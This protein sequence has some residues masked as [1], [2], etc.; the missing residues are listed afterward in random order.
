[1][2][3]LR[4][5]HDL[6]VRYRL[7]VSYSAVFIL[8][9]TVGSIIV[10]TL[11]RRTIEA[12]IESKLNNS[13]ATILDM[14][15]T[16]ITVSIKNHLRAVA[17]K[18][19]EIAEHF[20]SL[21]EQGVL[22]EEDPKR[23]AIAILF[24]QRIGETGYIY[25]AN[26]AGVAVVHPQ[27]AVQG[28]NFS[29][30][31]FV[32]EQMSRKEG[33]I[34]YEWKNPGDEVSRPKALYMTYFPAWDWIISASSYREEFRALINTEDFRE[35]ILSLR[36]GQTG[37]SYVMDGK[38]NLIIHPKLEGQN[39]LESS[40]A[41]GRHFIQEICRQKSGKMIYPWKNPDEPVPR[42]K[43]VIFNYVPELDWIVASSGYLDELYSPLA[44]VR[45][46]FFTTL[47]VSLLLV[48]PVTTRIS[49]SITS[50]LKELMRRFASAGTRDL[51]VRANTKSKD[52]LGQLG[53]YFNT[54][55][56]RLEEYNTSL[57]AEIFERKQAEQALRVSEEMFSKAFRLSP[58]GI[59]IASLKNRVVVDVN[60]SLLRATGYSHDEVI[61]KTA[62]ELGVF[63]NREEG[64][65]LMQRLQKK[66]HLRNREIE[67]RTKKGDTRIGMLSAEL[68]ELGG[69]P[70]MLSTIEDITDSRRMEKEIMDIADGERQRIGHDLHDDLCPHLIGIEVLSKV[71]S[72]K[73]SGKGLE[74]AAHA[75]RIRTLI[76]QAIDKTRRF[77]RGLCPVHLVAYGL[78]TALKEL[79]SKAEEMFGVSCLF[80]GDQPVLVHDNTVATHLFY[81][82]QEA[83]HNAIKH[84]EANQILIE[85]SSDDNGIVL[86]IRDNGEGM[87]ETFPSTGMGL[88]IMSYRAK[89]IGASLEIK[90]DEGKGTLVKCS[91]RNYD[92]KA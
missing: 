14:V 30:F 39:Y 21:H 15:R 75:D 6:P 56:E 31:P 22:S 74:E 77:A 3:L 80:K 50:P 90:R 51:T 87:P 9:L 24:S 68:I 86:E 57:H 60:E 20:Y 43:L 4:L 65:R 55:M 79:G 91:L 73:L 18:N 28:V 7:L 71:L 2:S 63:P 11:V 61:G 42:M 40:D 48:I 8:A 38:G 81:I 47:V 59:C 32:Q 92:R 69:E 19:R 54:F 76:V 13:T 36:F 23:G 58:N 53:L 84:G 62:T 85:L 72:K 52:E 29:T 49:S 83:V 34:E 78:E 37:Y 89:L 44:T 27:K 12:N 45:N 46:V 70:A 5:F 26:S 35:S 33:Y 10:Y 66:G 1:M 67:F 64:R 25:C 82:A 88:R 17:E 41:T 16:S